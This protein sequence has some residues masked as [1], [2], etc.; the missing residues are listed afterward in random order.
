[1]TYTNCLFVILNKVF[2]LL[3]IKPRRPNY[4]LTKIMEIKEINKTLCNTG[5]KGGGVWARN[6]VEWAGKSLGACKEELDTPVE[7][8]TPDGIT[9]CSPNVLRI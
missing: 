7:E 5:P 6:C 9:T 4:R 8:S 2:G 1:M 3:G